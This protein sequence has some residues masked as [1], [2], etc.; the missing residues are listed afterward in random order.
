MGKLMVP[1]ELRLCFHGA[2]TLLFFSPS[3][4]FSC[5]AVWVRRCTA[6]LHARLAIMVGGVCGSFGDVVA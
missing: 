3:R 5:L 4:S 2:D 1:F 6:L